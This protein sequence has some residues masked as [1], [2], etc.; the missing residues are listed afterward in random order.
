M[1][2]ISFIIPCYN[3]AK[4]LKETLDPLLELDQDSIEVIIVNDGSTDQT[5]EIA[6]SYKEKIKNFSILDQDNQGVSAA[7]NNGLKEASGK[8]IQ[9]LDSDDMIVSNVY[10]EL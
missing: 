6:Q 1:I 5:L 10:K 7:R 4:F 3:A 8:Y 9:F 2:Q